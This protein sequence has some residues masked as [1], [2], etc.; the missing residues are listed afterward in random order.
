MGAKNHG[1]IMPDADKEDALNAVVSATFGATGQRCMALSVVIM[2]GKAREWVPDIVAKAKKLK[3]GPGSMEGVDVA[4][5]C[6]K[7]L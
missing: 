5:L 7:E 4:P 3:I 2:V 6:Y 1:V